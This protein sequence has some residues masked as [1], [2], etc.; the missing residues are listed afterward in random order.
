MVTN[1]DLAAISQFKDKRNS[2]MEARRQASFLFSRA[3]GRGR[4]RTFLHKLARREN[5]LKDLS[6]FSSD[7]NRQPP[8][9]TR[10]ANIP[11]SKI[12]GSEGRIHDFDDAF[13]PL[14]AHN[15][16][17]WIGIA[18]A[19]QQGTGLPPVE[20]IQ[21]GHQYYV[22]D[23]HHRISVARAFSQAEIEA[24]IVYVLAD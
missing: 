11:L 6:R 14:T 5:R 19:R 9:Q 21:A 2:G 15:R 12:V 22:R 24:H 16:D 8:K 17:R 13:N 20:L 4:R 1:M 18:A 3:L 10:V 23:G 7:A